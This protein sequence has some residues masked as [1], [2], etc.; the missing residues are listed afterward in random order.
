[1]ISHLKSDMENRFKE[2]YARL[3]PSQKEAVDSIEGPVMVVAGPGT[4]KTTILTL[5]IANILRQTDTPPDGILAL[6]FTEAGVVAMKKKL[7]QVIGGAADFV[8]IHTFHGFALSVMREFPEE[9]PF[10]SGA[11]QL[12]EIE[13]EGLISKILEN[14]EYSALRPS[15]RPEQYIAPTISSI[16]GCKREFVSPDDVRAFANEKV[17]EI[18]SDD[19]SYSTRGKTKGSLKAEAQNKIEKCH[20]TL[21]FADVF[22]EYERRKKEQNKYDYDD[23]ILELIRSFRANENLLRI[24]QERSLYILVDEHQDTNDSQNGI[25]KSVAD[26]FDNPNVFIVGDEK[27]AIFRFQGASVENFLKFQDVWPGM[28]IIRLADNYRSH[29]HILDAVFSMIENNYEEGQ[30]ENLRI[31]LKA[32][33]GIKEKPISVKTAESEKEMENYLISETKKILKEDKGSEV[34][35]I[36]R[37]NN[38]LDKIIRLFNMSDV[39][40]S[41]ERNIDIFSSP[42]GSLFLDCLEFAAD[43]SKTEALARSLSGGAWNVS[44]EDRIR[45]IRGLKS[46]VVSVSDITAKLQDISQKAASADPVA[47]LYFLA[48]QSGMEK[49]FADTPEGVEIWRGIISFAEKVQ[50]EDGGQSVRALAEKFSAYRESKQK[51]NVKV[52]TGKTEASVKVMTAH[53]SKG[54][55]FDY[56]FLPYATEKAWFKK[57]K[58]QY[59]LLPKTEDAVDEVKDERRLFYVGLTRSRKHA[60]ILFSEK[61]S[62]GDGTLPLRFISELNPD[63]VENL[64]ITGSKEEAVLFPKKTGLENDAWEEKIIE[65]GKHVICNSGLSVTALNHFLECPRKFLY[66]SILKVPEPPSASAEKGTSLHEAISAVWNSPRTD[67]ESVEK[68]LEK[69]SR[70]YLENKSFLPRFEKEAVLKELGEEIPKIASSLVSH[71][72][73][74]DKVY[75]ENWYEQTADFA[76]P[77]EGQLPV[78]LHGKLDAVFVGERSLSVFDYKSKLAM[79][80]PAIKGETKNDNGDYFRQLVFYRRLLKDN[81]KFKELEQSFSL[82]FIKPDKKGNCKAVTLVVLESDLV[83]LEEEIQTL[84]E[85]VWSGEFIKGNCEKS[86]CQWCR[87]AKAKMVGGGGNV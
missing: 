51:R 87:L 83:R 43:S 78:K 71:F 8:K 50:K 86:D 3:N 73:T 84:V 60:E 37:T 29:R 35:I 70:N 52:W 20:K 74:E 76:V 79:S 65:Y 39:P 23:I 85:S 81:P 66:K 75:A 77:E 59:F 62:A 32:S 46:A 31:K 19:S 47:F 38:D 42:L 69:E 9:F 11:S 14:H 63:N 24:I 21:I 17:K 68:T 44:F 1:M 64:Y 22:E 82:Y 58:R 16:S 57:N 61:D 30:H 36:T 12:N 27:Q 7:R 5:R 6:T 56:V 34:A 49:M 28:K 18:K 40:F 33:S 13:I 53:G 48:R 25:I 15:G 45:L 54:L 10:I 4:G 26:F 72:K 80:E 67:I 2:K 55:E 41:A